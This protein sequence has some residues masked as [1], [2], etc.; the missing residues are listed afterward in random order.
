MLC[1][2]REGDFVLRVEFDYVQVVDGWQ[3][4]VLVCIIVRVLSVV[5]VGG[6]LVHQGLGFSTPSV[7][8]NNRLQAGGCRP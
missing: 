2:Q 6:G 4:Y 5:V 1:A 7:Y 3:L 8:A